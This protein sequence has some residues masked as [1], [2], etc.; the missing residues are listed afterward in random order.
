MRASPTK[1]FRHSSAREPGSVPI[2]HDTT[3]EALR[4]SLARLRGSGLSTCRRY[5][6]KCRGQARGAGCPPVSVPQANRNRGHS[7]LIRYPLEPRQNLRPLKRTPRRK[8]VFVIQPFNKVFEA[9]HELIASAAS[10]VNATVIRADSVIL[11]GDN[12]CNDI[13]QCNSIRRFAHRGRFR[14]Q[15]QRRMRSVSGAQACQTTSA[16]R[17]QQS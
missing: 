14:C 1:N 16:H 12:F 8:T 3:Y 7:T 17:G 10:Q 6:G 13:T 11:P 15:P 9:V 4:Q 5:D 2:V